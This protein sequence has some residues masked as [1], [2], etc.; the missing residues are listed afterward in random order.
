MTIAFTP[1]T[2]QDPHSVAKGGFHGNGGELF[3]IWL[4]NGILT[5]LTLGIYAAWGKAK[6]YRYFYS[7][8]EFAGSRF[9]FTGTGKEIFI[10]M[11]KALVVFALLFGF[12]GGSMA[13]A[14]AAHVPGLG[15]VAFLVFYAVL[16]VITQMA[17]FG[18]LRYRFS[19][20]R[21]REIAF[22]LEG[23]PWQFAKEALPWLL[24]TA[25]SL[26]FAAPLY[27]HWRI[28]RIYNNLSF[29]NLPF[30]WDAEAGAYWRLCLK[31][32]FLSVLTLGVYYFFWYPKMFAFVRGHMSVA[33]NRFGGEIRSGEF[34]LLAATNLLLAMCTLGIAVPW[35]LVRTMR[36]YLE[37]LELENPE[38]LE[39]AL[40]V[41][42]Q[43]GSTGGEAVADA[44]DLGVGIGF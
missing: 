21:Y 19:R 44:M 4:V 8:T 15:I 17:M 30:K 37:R 27:L 34:F 9:R 5:V 23:S 18:A 3:L 36:F 38:S 41:A 25:V 11:L 42:A 35:I 2:S 7:S 13:A 14:Q 10:G 43:T 39:A 16:A 32:F 26:G 28:S 6:I 24:L 12:L 31:G 29:G 20:A 40:Q 1:S 33:G 22:R